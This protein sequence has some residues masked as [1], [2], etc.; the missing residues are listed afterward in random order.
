MMISNIQSSEGMSGMSAMGRPQGGAKSKEEIESM[1]DKAVTSG[2]ITE[3]EAKQ[4]KELLAKGPRDLD[5]ASKSTLDGIM[6]KVDPNFGKMGSM[7][8]PP[9]S[10]GQGQKQGMDIMSLLDQATEN[11]TINEDEAKQ[12]KSLLSQLK[13]AMQKK[14]VDAF[15]TAKDSLDSI[16]SKISFSSTEETSLDIFNQQV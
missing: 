13:E 4:A 11:G 2:T 12:A 1:F 10:G 16:M 5:S 3:D 15:N 9:P 6:Q 8:P 14:D 7:P